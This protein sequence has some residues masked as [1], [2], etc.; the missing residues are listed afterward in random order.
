[1]GLAAGLCP[2]AEPWTAGPL[3]IH[4]GQ[5]IFDG[6]YSG[7]Q[8]FAPTFATFAQAAAVLAVWWLLGVWL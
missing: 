8:V 1:M 3:W 6:T 7:W 2:T 4:F 5:L